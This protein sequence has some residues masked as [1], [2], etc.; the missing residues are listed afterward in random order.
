VLV[1]EDDAGTRRAMK[2]LLN[3]YNYDV[4]MAGTVAEA[5]AEVQEQP[6]FILLDL[7]L[8]DGDGA[9]VLK[10]VR[11]ENLHSRVT[12]VTGTN[13][14]DR[15]RQIQNLHPEMLLHKPVDFNQILA[16]FKTVD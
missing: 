4:V 7:M 2:M 3:Y 6:D 16:Q 8:P 13:D 9:A 10:R 15:L 11:D 1:V 5:M 12:V 14:P